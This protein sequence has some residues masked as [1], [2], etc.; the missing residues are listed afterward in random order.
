MTMTSLV[1]VKA[2]WELLV[3]VS[4][5]PSRPLLDNS[6]NTRD[7]QRF[8]PSP[9]TPPGDRDSSGRGPRSVSRTHLKIVSN[10]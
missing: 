5:T 8:G 1:Y 9:T 4:S 3:P 10:Q 6:T 7:A 2:L